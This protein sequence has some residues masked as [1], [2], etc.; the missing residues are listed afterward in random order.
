MLRIVASCVWCVCI[1]RHVI[2][3]ISYLP[4]TMFGGETFVLVKYISCM[5]VRVLPPIIYIY[6]YIYLYLHQNDPKDGQTYV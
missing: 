6:I 2:Y 1:M 4:M 3:N 5:L